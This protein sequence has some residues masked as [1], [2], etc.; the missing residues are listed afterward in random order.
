MSW[1]AA[2]AS[3]SDEA[4]EA[5]AQG[6]PWRQQEVLATYRKHHRANKHKMVPIPVCVIPDDVRQASA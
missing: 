2:H 4:R 6:L 1:E 5:E 3:L